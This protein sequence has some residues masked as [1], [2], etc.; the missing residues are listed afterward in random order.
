[1]N[2]SV[3]LRELQKSLQNHLLTKEKSINQYIAGA[4]PKIISQRLAIYGDGYRYRLIDVLATYYDVL[5][6]Y[7]GDENFFDLASAYIA[8]F[9]SRYF[10][11]DLFPQHLAKFLAVTEPYKNQ[12]YLSELANFIWLLNTTI[13]SAD[14]RILTTNDLAKIPQDSWGEMRFTFHPSVK[15]LTF[16]WNALAIW[17]AIIQSQEVPQPSVLDQTSFCVVWRK[18]MQPYYCPLSE[19]QAWVFQA[20][21]NNQT[22][23]E[24][25]E[26]LLKWVSEDQ[27][28]NY[29]ASLLLRWLND[30]MFSEVTI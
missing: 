19:D 8:A 26:G 20:L 29:A 13:D 1:M 18:S 14:A 27:A 3:E 25:C 5:Y 10:S 24:V 9:P 11:V 15:S 7:V 28:A 2:A 12:F 23:E 6:K 17:Q 30:E 4:T 22:F 16:N 21:K